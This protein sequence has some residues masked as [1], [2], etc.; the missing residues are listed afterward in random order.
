VK[1]SEVQAFTINPK[2]TSYTSTFIDK[3]ILLDEIDLLQLGQNDELEYEKITF[4]EPQ[5]SA[6]DSY[7]TQENPYGVHRF[8]G[9]FIEIR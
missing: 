7:P 3:H 6:I 8:A 2:E 1:G 4:Q 5:T 9:I